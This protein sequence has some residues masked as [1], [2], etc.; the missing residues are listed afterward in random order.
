MKIFLKSASKD[1]VTLFQLTALKICGHNEGVHVFIE[2]DPTL[3]DTAFQDL[4]TVVRASLLNHV[5]IKEVVFLKPMLSHS[6]AQT[7]KK[8][9]LQWETSSIK[10]N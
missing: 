9:G 2:A 1:L 5:N 8:L 4:S 7:Q 6:F 3:L 10:G